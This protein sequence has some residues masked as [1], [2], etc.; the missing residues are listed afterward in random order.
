MAQVVRPLPEQ[1]L[2]EVLEQAGPRVLPHDD[3]AR[4]RDETVEDLTRCRVERAHRRTLVPPCR[5]VGRRRPTAAMQSR[6]FGR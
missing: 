3:L 6:G 4:L 1:G 2:P 5:Q